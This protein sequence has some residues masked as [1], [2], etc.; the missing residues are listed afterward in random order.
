[1]YSFRTTPASLARFLPGYLVAR[2]TTWWLLYTPVIFGISLRTRN[3]S[4][5]PGGG[6]KQHD[7]SSVRHNL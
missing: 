1:M 6:V 5:G 4:G 7:L 2:G 3:G